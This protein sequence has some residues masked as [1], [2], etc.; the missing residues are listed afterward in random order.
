MKPPFRVIEGG[1]GPTP[2]GKPPGGGDDGQMEARIAKLEASAQHIEGDLRDVKTD[3][4]AFRD[5]AERDFRLTF[6]AIIVV[7]LG[8]A[9]LMAKGFKWL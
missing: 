2:L 9:G 7:A 1:G 3:L 6:G 8:L 5:K 4:R